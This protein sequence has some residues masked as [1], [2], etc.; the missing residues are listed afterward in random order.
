LDKI[1]QCFLFAFTCQVELIVFN[2]GEV[3]EI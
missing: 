2:N 3:T 1:I